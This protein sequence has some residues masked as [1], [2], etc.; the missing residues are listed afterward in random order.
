M[1]VKDLKEKITSSFIELMKYANIGNVK[2]Y[3]NILKSVQYLK[4]FE[5]DD[6]TTELLYNCL[7]YENDFRFTKDVK[8]SFLYLGLSKNINISPE[9]WEEFDISNKKSI[10]ID[11]PISSGYN[12]LFIKTPINIRIKNILEEDITS[13]FIFYE[14]KNGYTTL[15]LKNVYNTSLPLKIT[16]LWD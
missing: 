1:L 2:P 5:Y 13:D 4:Y 3:D 8:S 15:H 7:K 10:S 9:N 16:I 11:T 6:K 12:Y 14:R